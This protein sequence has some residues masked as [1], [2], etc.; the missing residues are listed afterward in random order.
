M[1]A[2]KRLMV[3]FAGLVEAAADRW[4]SRYCPAR[5]SAALLAVSKLSPAVVVTGGSAGIGLAIAAE[6]NRRGRPVL[7]IARDA[8]R[9]DTAAASVQLTTN[10]T[11]TATASTATASTATAST[12]TASTATAATATP[13]TV[14]TLTLD[15]TD[16]EAFAR[17][18]GALEHHG[19]YCDILVNAAA[20]GLSGPLLEQDPA[21]VEKLNEVNVTALTRLTRAALP[22]MTERCRGG[23]IN[24]GSLGGYVPGPHQAAYYA[25]KAYVASLTA[26][27]RAETAG[28]GVRIMELAPGP[29]ETGF[30]AAMGAET[31]LYRQ[32]LPAMSS[33]RVAR[34][35]IIGFAFGRGVVVP[36]FMPK[37]LAVAVSVLP[38]ALTVPVVAVLLRNRPSPS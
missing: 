21:A 4:L 38:N 35:A 15:V 19:W 36:G 37:L 11:P 16:P 31:A 12:A 7:L 18:N 25:S 22:A 28:C 13:S 33:E 23:V 9:L 5:S 3:G 6:F 24:V 2:V 27:L 10:G 20:C 14:A 30:H 29:V 8:A 32:L 17:I 34:A 26:A 1:A